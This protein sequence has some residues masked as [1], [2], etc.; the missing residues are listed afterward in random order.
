[1]VTIN[2]ALAKVKADLAGL[3]DDQAI[4]ICCRHLGHRWRDTLLNPAVTL[5]L[6]VMQVLAG[7]TACWALRHL[8]GL[9]FTASAY[10]QARQ[11]LPLAVIQQLTRPVGRH[12]SAEGDAA[13]LWHGHRLWLVDGSS[14]SMPDTPAL[15]EHFGQPSGQAQ[16][17]GFP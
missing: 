1:M 12:V 15:Q 2:Q 17:C 10:C 14:V 9:T 6:F 7:N 8:S 4:F 11:R 16:G 13:G 3:L 5:H